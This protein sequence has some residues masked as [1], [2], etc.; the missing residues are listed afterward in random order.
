[1]KKISADA[2]ELY[3]EWRLVS[4]LADRC[5]YFI[6]IRMVESGFYEEVSQSSRCCVALLSSVSSS[7]A[8]R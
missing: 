8:G 1:M 2:G 4:R 7:I 3:K 6:P 5:F